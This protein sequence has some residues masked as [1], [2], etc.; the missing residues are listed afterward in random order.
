MAQSAA[1]QQ[2]H[3]VE[4]A[5]NGDLEKAHL[6][7]REAAKARKYGVYDGAAESYMELELFQLKPWGWLHHVPEE[8]RPAVFHA[9]AQMATNRIA[10]TAAGTGKSTQQA[11]DDFWLRGVMPSANK[12]DARE[13]VFANAVAAFVNRKLG[14]LPDNASKA[15]RDARAKKIADT[16][17]EQRPEKP[18]PEQEAVFEKAIANAFARANVVAPVKE[19]KRRIKS[20]EPID[21]VEIE[22]T[23]EL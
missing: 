19:K 3:P 7:F 18:S 1:R 4:T 13:K 8:M 11:V 12:N 16:L 15:E 2:P 21:A 6:A 5:E 20:G 14:P 10:Q 17:A 23:D 22:D 9:M